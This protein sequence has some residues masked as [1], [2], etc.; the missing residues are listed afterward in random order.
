M[1]DVDYFAR[2]VHLVR[3]DLCRRDIWQRDICRIINIWC[4]ISGGLGRTSLGYE[5]L[6]VSSPCTYC[7]IDAGG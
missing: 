1:V 3:C 7:G 4:L 5:R 6:L 2:D